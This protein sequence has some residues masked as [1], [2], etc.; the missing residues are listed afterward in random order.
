MDD[1]YRIK[2]FDWTYHSYTDG[3]GHTREIYLS[4]SWGG[5]KV[6]LKPNEE[7]DR[8]F[9]ASYNFEDIYDEEYV[10]FATLEEAKQWCWD[11]WLPRITSCLEKVQTTTEKDN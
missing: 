9:K 11:N 4:K 5:Y 7:E 6:E 8:P 2:P 3:E 10:Y 1:L